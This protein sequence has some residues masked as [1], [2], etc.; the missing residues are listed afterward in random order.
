MKQKTKVIINLNQS[1]LSSTSKN[2]NESKNKHTN[3]KLRPQSSNLPD[4]RHFRGLSSCFC[5]HRKINGLRNKS[6]WF[7]SYKKHSY[8]DKKKS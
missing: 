3:T 2:K 8:E 4:N 7:I 6:K 5:F 1:T